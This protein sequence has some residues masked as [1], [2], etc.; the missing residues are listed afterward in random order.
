MS[1]SEVPPSKPIPESRLLKN[2]M[3]S[4]SIWSL[5]AAVT[6][7]GFGLIVFVLLSRLLAPTDFGLMAMAV[8]GVELICTFMMLGLVDVVVRK[9]DLSDA[10]TSTFFWVTAIT[11]FASS[12]AIFLLCE[13]LAHMF[14]QPQIAPMLKFLAIM[15]ML[16][17]LVTVPQGLLLREMKFKRFAMRTMWSSIGAGV[18]SVAM[19]FTGFGVYS[20]V[21]QRISSLAIITFSSWTLARW[22]PRL[23]LRPQTVREY[24]PRGLSLVGST[25]FNTASIRSVDLIAGFVLGPAAVGFYRIAGKL[26]DFVVQFLIDPIVKVALPSFSRIQ[27]DRAAL[28]KMYKKLTQ[29]CASVAIPAFVG[30]AILAPEI[31]AL[32]FGEKWAISGQL[33][34]ILCIASIGYTLNYF[35]K[36]LMTVLGYTSEI[37]KT[38]F[39]NFILVSVSTLILARFSIHA[40]MV[41]FVIS[42]LIITAWN[43][44]RICKYLDIPMVEM[45]MGFRSS[46]ISSL[47]M[48][49]SILVVQQVTAFPQDLTLSVLLQLVIFLVIGVLGYLASM[50]IFFQKELHYTLGVVKDFMIERRMR[51]VTNR[52]VHK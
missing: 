36:P 23:I 48:A 31:V 50:R 29:M 15:P 19:A 28:A 7:Q 27:E 25:F 35:F 18:I 45:L 9:R 12:I 49:L 40:V 51:K 24:V 16:Q 42:N 32:V 22:R 43:L 21:F 10:D 2:K 44:A 38:Q 30:L 13:P 4:G 20:L 1:Y 37:F 26:N 6:R 11:G 46:I 52:Q 34:Q 41:G 8:A 17:S 33:M 39:V 3:L 47:V 14:G 5:I